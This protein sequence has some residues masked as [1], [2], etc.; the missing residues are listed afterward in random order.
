MAMSLP[1]AVVG[2]VTN[3]DLVLMIRRGPGGPNAG[4]WAP[5]TGKIE[6]GEESGRGGRSLRRIHYFAVSTW[7]GTI[8]NH[9]AAS[10]LWLPWSDLGCLD[11]ES[12][13]SP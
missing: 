13:A 2:V 10:L 1:D 6:L 12:I 3:A 7:E 11:V 9:E 8:T 4:Y 5:P